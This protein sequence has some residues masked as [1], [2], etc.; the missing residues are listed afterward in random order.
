MFIIMSIFTS[1][2]MELGFVVLAVIEG[3]LTGLEDEL[4]QA[5]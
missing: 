3:L 1:N 2:T 4:V 5:R